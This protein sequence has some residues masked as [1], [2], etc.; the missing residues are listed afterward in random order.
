M[1]QLRS[2]SVGPSSDRHAARRALGEACSAL[3][4][5][6]EAL[7]RV[8]A[9]RD[10]DPS[11]N[12]A[13]FEEASRALT[14]AEALQRR[15]LPRLGAPPIR[16][17]DAPRP[18]PGFFGALL[19]GRDVDRVRALEAILEIDE[20]RSRL[21]SHILAP[22]RPSADEPEPYYL[23][24]KYS[25]VFL[26]RTRTPRSWWGLTVLLLTLMVLLQLLH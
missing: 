1:S 11:H 12:T 10:V 8:T 25:G 23:Q 6:A 4:G 22:S 20:A 17:P 2:I 15:A 24:A 26:R 7:A 21:T 9:R 16:V 19:G 13:C 5:A 14:R 18:L 3:T